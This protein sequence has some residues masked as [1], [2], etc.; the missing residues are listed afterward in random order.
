MRLPLRLHHGRRWRSLGS[1]HASH[2]LPIHDFWEVF[3]PIT[4]HKTWN[5]IVFYSRPLIDTLS[6]GDSGD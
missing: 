4:S 3:A 1:G 6:S 2:V 5:Y